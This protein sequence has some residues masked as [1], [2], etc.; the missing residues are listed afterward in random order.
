MSLRAESH[1]DYPLVEIENL[2]I[3]GGSRKR[4][5]QILHGVDLYVHRGEV[6]GLIGES[7]AGKSTLGLAVMGFA[8]NGTWFESGSVKFDGVELNQ[9]TDES[10]L[11]E[12]WGTKV[13]YV[14]QSAAAAFNPSWTLMTQIVETAV[15]QEVMT[16]F[17]AR[18][19]AIELF[20]EL[21]LPNPDSFGKRYPHQV[22]G[23]Q[24]Q[25]AMVAMAMICKPELIIFDEP[26]TALDVTTQIEVL[27][28]IK[29]VVSRFQTA[30]IYVTHDL[31]VVAQ[32]ADNITVMRHGRVVECRPTEEL[33]NNPREEYTRNLLNSREYQAGSESGPDAPDS[34]LSLRNVS[35]A[36]GAMQ[37]LKDISFD[38]AQS[39]TVAIVGESG[40]GKSTTAR[41]LTG[42]LVPTKGKV[43]FE[44]EELQP[45]LGDRPKEVLRRIQM[46]SQMPDTALNPHH[47]IRKIIGRPLKF[48][49][50]LRGREQ[51]RRIHELLTLIELDPD[52]FID[53][54]PP[55]LSGGQKQRI[56]IAKALAAE[57]RLLICDEVT[58]ALDQLVA[59]EIVKLLMRLQSQL[60]IAMIFIAHDLEL[61][62][63]IAHRVIVM[64]QGKI[65]DAGTRE[66]VFEPPHDPYTEI[67]LSSIPEMDPNWLDGVIAGRRMNQPR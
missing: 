19:N 25:R 6:M 18:A 65:V 51:K 58:S 13:A 55:E 37:I 62:G 49:F 27:A 22:S 30:A 40:S 38:V 16:R 67:L 14:A 59:K 53:R 45:A 32:M 28:S 29:N 46:V 64:Q 41:A 35:A 20:R 24:L 54:M 11:R 23:G 44:G 42:L 39:E 5:V 66:E 17:E 31:S 8:R 47:R 56:C 12:I 43:I 21:Y 4:P 10:E 50:G 3:Q 26:T 63:A 1:P 61:V 33:L 34:V 60:K 9:V 15:D 52:V 36:Y 2:K 57:P 48:Y 7:G